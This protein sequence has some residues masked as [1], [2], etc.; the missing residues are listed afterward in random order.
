MPAVR[1]RGRTEEAKAKPRSDVYV[2]LLSLSLLALLVAMLFAYLNWDAIKA[3][4]PTV[5]P[6]SGS[7]MP[8]GPGPGAVAP[9]GGQIQPGNVPTPPGAGGKAPPPPAPGQN[10]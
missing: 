10:K 7:R 3:K 5:Q 1:S 4:P 8:A 2:G 9:P 6:I